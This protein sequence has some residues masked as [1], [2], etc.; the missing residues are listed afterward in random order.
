MRG[1]PGGAWCRDKYANG[2]SK[3]SSRED[4]RYYG[5]V[6]ILATQQ[7][8]GHGEGDSAK[9]DGEISTFGGSPF[10]LGNIL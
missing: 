9:L 5:W 8:N 6:E 4:G 10:R 1:E 7:V 3:T 2:V